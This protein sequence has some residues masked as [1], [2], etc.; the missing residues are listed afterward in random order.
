MLKLQHKVNNL[1]YTCMHIKFC[2]KLISVIQTDAIY[3]KN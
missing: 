3:N 2:C 1:A